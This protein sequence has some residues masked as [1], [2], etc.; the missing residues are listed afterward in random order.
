MER[1]SRLDYTD[2]FIF[3]PYCIARESLYWHCSNVANYDGIGL[4]I[5]EDWAIERLTIKEIA[6][7]HVMSLDKVRKLLH[8]GA[9]EYKIAMEYLTSRG[10]D[11]NVP[12]K[13]DAYQLMVSKRL[14]AKEGNRLIQDRCRD[15]RRLREFTKEEFLEKFR[16]WR[17]SFKSIY[18]V[19]DELGIRFKA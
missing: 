8:E 4:I 14:R 1:L 6:E 15:L 5:L 12:S 9:E 13:Y 7:N 3:D 10:V 18:K 17:L 16:G 2:E 19:M 11:T